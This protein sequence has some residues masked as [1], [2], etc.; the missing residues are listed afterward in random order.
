MTSDFQSIPKIGFIARTRSFAEKALKKLTQKER[1][2]VKK[3]LAAL[4][5]KKSF[6]LDIKKFKGRED[7]FRVRK[8]DIRIVYRN[9]CGAIFILLIERRNEKTYNS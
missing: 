6:G 8:G 9:S 5:S 7:I 2:Q 4:A 3:I 1:E